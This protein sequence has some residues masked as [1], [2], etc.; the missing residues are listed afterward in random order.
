M[1]DSSLSKSPQV[2]PAPRE[3]S[4]VSAHGVRAGGQKLWKSFWKT[5]RLY[6]RLTLL[7]FVVVT[8]IL[9]VAALI[10]LGVISR[11]ISPSAAAQLQWPIIGGALGL[12]LLITSAIVVALQISGRQTHRVTAVV[13]RLTSGELDARADM[14]M[15]G[16]V[17]RLSR[18]V[19][20]LAER[21]ERQA[22]ARQR[23]RDRLD[24]V[25]QTMSDGVIMLDRRGYVTMMNPAASRL[26]RAP[27]ETA[28][29][30][31]FVQVVRDYRLADVWQAVCTGKN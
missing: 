9:G 8:A 1:Q 14:S 19:N 26:L 4:A 24:T 30:Q 2:S 16:E 28:L 6:W 22:S 3:A 18:A 5:Q 10:L 29:H 25:L 21:T 20:Q 27:A 13:R 7:M 15:G 11:S 17:G 23:E 31:S 12:A